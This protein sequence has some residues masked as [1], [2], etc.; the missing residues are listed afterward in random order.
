MKFLLIVW[1]IRFAFSLLEK[2][3]KKEVEVTGDETQNHIIH[4]SEFRTRW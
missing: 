4:P 3:G 1:A 2:I